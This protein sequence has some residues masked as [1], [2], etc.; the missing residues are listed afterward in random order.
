GLHVVGQLG[1][2]TSGKLDA[3]ID[4]LIEALVRLQRP[5]YLRFGYEFDGV[6]NHYE[7]AAFQAAWLHFRERL[8]ASAARNIPMGWHSAGD[9]TPTYG[10]YPVDAWYPGDDAVDWIGLSW[11]AQSACAYHGPR[12]IVALARAHHKPVMIAESTPRGYDLGAQ[13]YSQ[14]GDQ[15]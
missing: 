14:Y 9:C 10:E 12:E 3:S 8:D 5:I 7:P 1:D 15:F 11:F 4:A 2:I 6:W 13:R